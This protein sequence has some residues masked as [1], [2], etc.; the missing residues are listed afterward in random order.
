MSYSTAWKRVGGGALLAMA[1]AWACAHEPLAVKRPFELPPSADLSYRLEAKQKGLALGGSGTVAWRAAA[2]KYSVASAWK[3]S[4][5]GKILENRSEGT[6]DAYGLAPTRF[7]EKR[8]RKDPTAAN[9]D[10]PS[11][12]IGFDGDK[13][14]YPIRGGEQDRSSVQWQLA[15]LARAAPEK[16]V[17]GSEWKFFVVGRRDAE[18]WTFRVVNRES[19][20]T[21][22]GSMEAVHLAR[23][24][25][26]DGKAQRVDLWLAPAHDWYPVKLRISEDDGEYI[27][28]TVT[29]IEKA[30]QPAS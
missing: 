20:K 2:G 12:I 13:M 5:L 7:F 26:A 30:G 17:P 14:T 6:L 15:A 29:R 27:E 21:G 3:A 1:A 28:Q 25:Q 24:P 19:I 9:F 23:A 10:R 8:F 22:I 11:R 16:F 4:F 18:V